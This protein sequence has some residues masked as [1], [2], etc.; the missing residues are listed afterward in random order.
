MVASTRNT[1]VLVAL[2]LL[3]LIVT[4]C[5]AAQQPQSSPSVSTLELVPLPEAPTPTV[6]ADSSPSVPV[7]PSRLQ[8]AFLTPVAPDGWAG[9]LIVSGAPTARQS[10]DLVHGGPVF[11]SWAITN[12]RDLAHVGPFMVDLMLDGVPVERWS[13]PGLGTGEIRSVVDWDALPVRARLTAGRHALTLSVDPTGLAQP[14][15]SSARTHTVYFE[16][17]EA[18]GAPPQR[19][20]AAARQPNLAVYTPDGWDDPINLQ[21]VVDRFGGVGSVLQVAFKNIGLSS[22][23]SFFQVHISVDGVMVAKFAQQGLVAD[24]TVVT[25][26]WAGLLDAM[27]L[28]PGRHVLQLLLD[29]TDLVDEVR[30]EDNTFA[31]EIVL[32]AD[33]VLT[34]VGRRADVSQATPRTSLLVPYVPTGW[35]ASLVAAGAPGRTAAPG[36]LHADAD[37][38]VSWAVQNRGGAD[39][40]QPYVI[41][42][43]VDDKRVGHWLRAGLAA[44]RTDFV[45]DERIEGTLPPGDHRLTLRVIED[46]PLL[47]GSAVSLIAERTL[48]WRPGAPPEREAAGLSTEELRE[49]LAVLDQLRSS[50]APTVA[51]G[52]DARGVERVLRLAEAVHFSIYGRTLAEEPLAIH[53]VTDAEFGDWIDVECRD[54]ASGLEEDARPLYLQNCDRA[55]GFAG[56]QTHWQ[57]LRRIVVKG[58]RPPMAVLGTLAHELGHFVQ[59]RMNPELDQETGLDFRA[60]REAQAYAHQ[61]LFIRKLQDL[62]GF[63]LLLY[64]RVGGYERFVP[65]QVQRFVAARG[66]DEHARGKLLLWLALLTD[67][68]LR[69]A[70]T[71]LFN[72]LAMTTESA[73][74]V[75]RYLAALVASQVPDY[76]SARFEGLA[77]QTPAIESLA[78]ARLVLG[79]PYWIEGPSEFREV[80]LLLP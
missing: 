12:T 56:Y 10:T 7:L 27:P 59:S 29:P 4:G 38:Y 76:V 33:G 36:P 68:E 14:G 2:L 8:Q 71:V 60:L 3:V 20:I 45:V 40:T 24:E 25:P 13:S 28:E 41:E 70:R 79:L 47:D 67:P 22:V 66:R 31:M 15:A 64:P 21:S 62:T 55:K 32:G 52:G 78:A 57:G 75:F 80:G 39:R 77:V 65:E 37:L 50:S 18:P 51:L 19:I 23:T 34:P 63:D 49:R 61:V 9:P 46:E 58:E 54:V 6:P 48:R 69:G 5:V 26:P 16:V 35:G 73:E 74:T 53:V 43:L 44:G 17:P 42:V 72:N 1:A 30:L 11:V